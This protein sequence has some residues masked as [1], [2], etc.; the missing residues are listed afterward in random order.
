[1]IR[2][3]AAASERL[4]RYLMR[5][6][7]SQERLEID[8]DLAEVRLRPKAGATTGGPTTTSSG[9]IRTRWW[10][11]PLCFH[12][13]SSAILCSSMSPCVHP[14]LLQQRRRLP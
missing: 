14:A 13:K 6:P 1:M 10:R 7:V 11:N 3:D 2:E 8:P 12:D 4:V 9:S 5:A